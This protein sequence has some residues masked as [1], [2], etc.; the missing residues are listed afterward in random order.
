MYAVG[1]GLSL[2]D[3]RIGLLIYAALALYYVAEPLLE[4]TRPIEVR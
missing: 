3:A 1:T 4:R 2:I